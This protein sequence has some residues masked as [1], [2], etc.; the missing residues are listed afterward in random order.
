MA[1]RKS[2]KRAAAEIPVALD[3]LIAESMFWP[4]SCRYCNTGMPYTRLGDWCGQC[5]Y[6]PRTDPRPA[7]GTFARQ[8]W[9]ELDDYLAR[10]QEAHS[11]RT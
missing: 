4:R 8:V 7:E 1:A 11:G 3:A 10:R 6:E 2:T 9:D 5:V